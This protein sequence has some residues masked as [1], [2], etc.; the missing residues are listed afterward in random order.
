MVGN[1]LNKYEI[2]ECIREG[3]TEYDL[4]RGDEAYKGKW[5]TKTRKNVEISFT[6]EDL[7]PRIY[8]WL[9]NSNLAMFAFFRLG[10]KLP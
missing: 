7:S 9:I 3:L 4:M 2:A 5:T 10:I 8:N 1:L 6:R